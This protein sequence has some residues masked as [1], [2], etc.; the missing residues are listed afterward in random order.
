MA[1]KCD[2]KYAEHLK[3][4]DWNGKTYAEAEQFRCVD[5]G[6]WLSLGESNDWIPSCEFELAEQLSDMLCDIV[7]L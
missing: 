7:K 2:H 5:C 3:R 4:G 6:A 1:N